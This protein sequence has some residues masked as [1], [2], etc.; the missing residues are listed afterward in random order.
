[1]IGVTPVGVDVVVPMVNV[2]VTG[3]L[4]VG[5]TELEGEKLQV[6]P[7]GNPLQESETAAL[8]D[9]DPVT[10]NVIGFEL[11]GSLALRVVDEN[12][13]MPKSTTCSVSGKS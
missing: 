13:P 1:V 6:A 12:E 11:L 4:D 5:F 7:V 8:N 9:P 10:W 2:T 3:V